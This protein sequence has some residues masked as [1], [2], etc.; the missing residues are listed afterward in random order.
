MQGVL[1]CLEEPYL[2][3]AAAGGELSGSDPWVRPLQAATALRNRLH[4]AA[5]D[6]AGRECDEALRRNEL[7]LLQCH[8]KWLLR[9]STAELRAAGDH[10]VLDQPSERGQ[11][12][13]M[14]SSWDSRRALKRLRFLA[15]SCRWQV[16]D[17][18]STLA[19]HPRHTAFAAAGLTESQARLSQ[20]LVAWLVRQCI[21]Q[22]PSAALQ[23]AAELTIAL[24]TDDE[25]PVED[26][27][28]RL[29]GAAVVT[30]AAAPGPAEE[31]DALKAV[32][33]AQ[34][35]VQVSFACSQP[36]LADG[37]LATPDAVEGGRR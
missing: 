11:T 2:Q 37:S 3:A 17:E 4:G 9:S 5:A 31:P 24:E 8:L 35:S 30:D 10:A 33:R 12:C 13:D 18:Q 14:T 26:E 23:K 1:A 20:H 32:S 36:L 21:D 29:C 27:V 16:P 15:K 28:S 34:C 7:A 22:L 19:L 6:A 25:A